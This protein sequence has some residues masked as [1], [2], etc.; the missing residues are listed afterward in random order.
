MSSKVYSNWS[1]RYV[2]LLFHR[3]EYSYLP[4]PLPP[5][6]CNV[7]PDA[8]VAIETSPATFF[9]TPPEPAVVVEPV[10]PSCSEPIKVLASTLSSEAKTVLV[11]SYTFEPSKST[12]LAVTGKACSR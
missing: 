4:S 1:L 10:N 3:L 7:M 11:P 9:C 12:G 5:S 8:L 2:N 6:S